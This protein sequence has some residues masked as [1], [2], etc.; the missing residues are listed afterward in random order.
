MCRDGQETWI[1]AIRM[2]DDEF[3]TIE[4][5]QLNYERVKAFNRRMIGTKWSLE[6]YRQVHTVAAI[7]SAHPSGIPAS[8]YSAG[9]ALIYSRA[10]ELR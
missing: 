10:A 9:D 3:E 1:E 6:D 4:A 7:R 8:G 2:P 5:E